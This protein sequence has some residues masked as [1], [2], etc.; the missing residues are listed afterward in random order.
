MVDF[1]ADIA[2]K[3]S[4]SLCIACMLTA[5]ASVQKPDVVVFS[6]FGTMSSEASSSK[7]QSKSFMVRS[8]PRPTFA[9]VSTCVKSSKVSKLKDEIQDQTTIGTSDSVDNE[10]DE[11]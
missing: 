2:R 6:G 11:L 3:N 10:E 5:S 9:T 1:Q 7:V 4:S 8:F